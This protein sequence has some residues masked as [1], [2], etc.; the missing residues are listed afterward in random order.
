MG[1]IVCVAHEPEPS[2]KDI[3]RE[4]AGPEVEVAFGDVPGGCVTL[5][6]GVPSAER[7][8]ADLAMKGFEK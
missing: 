7:I 8:D 4:T 2:A 3:L 5:V 1:L 6:E